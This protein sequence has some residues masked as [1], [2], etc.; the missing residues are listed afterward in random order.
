MSAAPPKT[1][2]DVAALGVPLPVALAVEQALAA[3]ARLAVAEWST[4]QRWS[5]RWQIVLLDRVPPDAYALLAAVGARHWAA[6]ARHPA[7][8]VWRS[9]WPWEIPACRT[10]GAPGVQS[11]V[12]PGPGAR[13]RGACLAHLVLREG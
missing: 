4:S 1:L 3:G 2:A 7:C 6:R 5:I 8:W 13:D 12:T 11:L 10:C 9:W